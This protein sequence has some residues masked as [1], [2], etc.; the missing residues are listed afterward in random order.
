M[1]ENTPVPAP[2]EGPARNSAT[3]LSTNPLPFF[4]LG[5]LGL[6]PFFAGAIGI[7]ITTNPTRIEVQQWLLT[8]AAVALSFAG[9][10]HWGVAMLDRQIGIGL[11]WGAA[12][13][14]IVPML[15]AWI[16]LN[17]G[18]RRGLALIAVALIIHMF[19]DRRLAE[20][21]SLPSWYL[22]LRLILTFGAVVSIGF[23]MLFPA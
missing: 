4:V 7:W 2:R 3:T 14:S 15:A 21:A 18:A 19:V 20:K 10:M 17:V 11:R 23:T 5:L 16:A 1:D 22:P 8:Y 9:A 12:L 13:W 6:L